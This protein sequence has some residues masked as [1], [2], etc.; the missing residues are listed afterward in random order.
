MTPKEEILAALLNNANISD[1]AMNLLRNIVNVNKDI[2]KIIRKDPQLLQ[3]FVSAGKAND[4]FDIGDE[5][6]IPWTDNSGDSPV[7]Y[8]YPFIVVD[9]ADCYDDQ[10]IK[11][12]NALWLQAKY[13]TPQKIHYDA[14]E[15]TIVDLNS[16]T[17]AQ[18]GWYY[19][20]KTG[21]NYTKL[22]LN[23]GDEIPTNYDSIH[24]C[25]LNES[26]LLQYGYANYEYSAIRQWLNSSAAKNEG[27]WTSQHLG[28]IAPNDIYQPG[29]LFG[30][31]ESWKTIFKPVKVITRARL[32][33]INITYD[34]FFIPSLE[35]LYGEDNSVKENTYWPYWKKIT[36]LSKPFKGN[37]SNKLEVRKM[38]RIDNIDN[39][40]GEAYYTRTG[41][42]T[43]IQC[44][45]ASGYFTGITTGNAMAFSCT[46][47]C[48]IY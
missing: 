28:D 1:E 18:E 45:T 48:V 30:F 10:N 34:K 20:G 3:E 7:T 4:F 19:F 25:F 46:P 33:E 47:S 6:I 11:H 27:W 17:T 2:N 39:V 37:T 26:S 42:L 14:V 43:S 32:N 38:R 41:V 40:Y 22:N 13:L 44:G 24:K 36:G 31:T 29:W 5:I 12:E 8:Q 15:D 35:Q 9:I 23:I 16:E 21:N